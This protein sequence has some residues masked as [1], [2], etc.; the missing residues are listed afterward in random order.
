MTIIYSD[1]SFT[2]TRLFPVD[3]SGLTNFPRRITE[4]PISP[5]MEIGSHTF[6]PN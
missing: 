6:C 3:I 4:S 1:D 2:R 5:D